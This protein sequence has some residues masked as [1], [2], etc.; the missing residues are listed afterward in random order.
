MQ[1]LHDFQ[2]IKMEYERNLSKHTLQQEFIHLK[3]WKQKYDKT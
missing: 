3:V 2:N 1:D